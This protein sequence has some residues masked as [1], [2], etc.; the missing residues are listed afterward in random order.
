MLLLHA[1]GLIVHYSG[2]RK[3]KSCGA[4]PCPGMLLLALA[5]LT[6]APLLR[7]S[8]AS[9]GATAQ[10]GACRLSKRRELVGFV[11]PYAADRQVGRRTQKPMRHRERWHIGHTHCPEGE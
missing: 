9:E 7:Q 5:T 3:M 2:F 11:M 4:E 10:A 1:E 6:H 8:N